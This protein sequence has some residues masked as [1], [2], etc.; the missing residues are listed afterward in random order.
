[1]TAFGAIQTL[2]VSNE[3]GIEVPA[4]ALRSRVRTDFPYL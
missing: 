4:T 3:A 2:A 1:M